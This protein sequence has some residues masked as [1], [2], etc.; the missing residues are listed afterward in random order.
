M[1]TINNHQPPQPRRLNA[2]VLFSLFTVA[3]FLV[4]C[5]Q[6]QPVTEAPAAETSSPP[7]TSAEATVQQSPAPVST[8]SEQEML[9]L[10]QTNAGCELPCWWGITPGITPWS[11]ARTRLEGY[12]AEI[13]L[14]I[15]LD[16]DISK[17]G[18][19]SLNL[20]EYGR[21]QYSMYVKADQILG[22]AIH[23]SD[24][25]DPRSLI[26]EMNF[27]RIENVTSRLNGLTG[28]QFDL[29]AR[30]I[31]TALYSVHL[32]FDGTGTFLSYQGLSP[33]NNDGEYLLCPTFG[34]SGNLSP[35]ISV[36]LYDADLFNSA[37]DFFE[38]SNSFIQSG[39]AR[40]NSEFSGLDTE[41]FLA[42][43]QAEQGQFCFAA[44][45]P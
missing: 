37:E 12:G 10:L 36:I 24:Y 3:V 32:H 27:F 26:E 6:N 31:E 22:I 43:L 35:S 14:D 5:G 29:V 21:Y 16:G 42:R 11:E 13:S 40:T 38:V 9:T 4:A 25:S 44:T 33:L 19:Y 20:Q 18:V 39:Q 28:I 17:F 23:A 45:A 1:S 7:A 2:S 34:E 41:E 8:L 30:H 15:Q